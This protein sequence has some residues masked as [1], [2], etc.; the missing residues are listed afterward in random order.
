[1]TPG[2]TLT[3]VEKTFRSDF[4]SVLCDGPAPH[5]LDIKDEI[6]MTIYGEPA[7]SP[8]LLILERDRY[9]ET[10]NVLHIHRGGL[11]AII[12]TKHPKK[13]ATLGF[14]TN[15]KELIEYRLDDQGRPSIIPQTLG[16]NA[17][18]TTFRKIAAFILHEIQNPP[19][20]LK[21][22]SDENLVK[23]LQNCLT[24]IQS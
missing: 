11:K 17:D 2:V 18:N 7:R 4:V 5:G 24:D 6:R 15:F 3:K 22:I 16:S 8:D 12:E 10:D 21:E 20:K 13:F 1:M 9:Q 19:P 23:V 14:V